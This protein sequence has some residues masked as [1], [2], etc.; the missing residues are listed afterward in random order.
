M[1]KKY[2]ITSDGFPILFDEALIHKH[3]SLNYT[4][5]SA[6]FF[7]T[8]IIQ[9]ENR[10]KVTCWGESSSLHIRSKPETDEKIIEALLNE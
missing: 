7:K 2:V 5:S 3:V 9:P 6:G 8:S 4:I 10:I 1:K